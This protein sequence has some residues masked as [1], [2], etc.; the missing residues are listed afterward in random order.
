MRKSLLA[1]ALLGAFVA[2]AVLAD[3]G[4]VILYGKVNE[5]VKF[6]KNA[7]PLAGDPLHTTSQVIIG[8]GGQGLNTPSRIGFKGT[9]DVG[10]G[11][12][13]WFQV[14]TGLTADDA[15][16]TSF[17]SREAWVGLQGAFGKVG[18][19]RGKTP[20]TNLADRFDSLVDGGDSLAVYRDATL[21]GIASTGIAG[22]TPTVTTNRFNNAIRYDSP[23][24]EGFTASAMWGAGENKTATTEATS[25]LSLGA[26]YGSGP[27][28]VGAAYN[29]ENRIGG[30][31]GRK[32]TA[33]LILGNYTVITDLTL[34][35]GYQHA[36]EE[37]P[38]VKLSRDYWMLD[39]TYTMGN[40]MLKGGAI[41]GEKAKLGGDSVPAA[42]NGTVDRTQY[43]RYTLG[44]NYNLSKRTYTYVEY[45]ADDN[46]H[47]DAL[48]LGVASTSTLGLGII[49]NF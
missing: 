14:E 30:V 23:N 37:A 1:A 45:T 19:G 8:N 27:V 43:V 15:T 28:F 44:M 9:E 42:I 16:A 40:I 32:N 20:Y 34:G 21:A 11:M 10:D 41:V 36:A 12:K 2:P 17:G 48:K 3:D 13:A 33:F 24:M 7:T 46:K 39:A 26:N 5:A 47:D 31:N 35:A 18:L 49:H 38:G 29:N 22:V 25:N 6:E 4:T